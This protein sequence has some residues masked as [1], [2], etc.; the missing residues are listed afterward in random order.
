MRVRFWGVRGSYPVSSKSVLRYGGHTS[1]VEIPVEGA[2]FHVIM[3][4][5]TGLPELGRKLLEG[6]CGEGRG[7][8][9][10]FLSHLH[11]DHVQG[12]PLFAPARARISARPV[13][14]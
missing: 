7:T 6:P 10:L 4:A 11:W 2:D 13:A 12:L 1:C 5:G 9:H 8:V 3:D 14:A